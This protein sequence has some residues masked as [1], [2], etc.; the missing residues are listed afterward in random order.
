MAQ[1]PDNLQLNRLL[2][3][4]LSEDRRIELEAHLQQ[5]S[6]CAAEFGRLR[7]VARLL[8]AERE[9]Y[10]SAQRLSQIGLHRL[11]GRVERAME[12]GVLRI[13]RV[14]NA[15]AACVLVAGSA[16][17]FMRPRENRTVE[18]ATP[19][20]PPWVD[21]SVVSD[22][23]TGAYSTPAAAWYLAEDSSRDTSRADAVNP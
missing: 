4:E 16:W 18:I 6:M 19:A 8:E 11:H 21:V 1:C 17:L 15:I 23:P 20:A 22:S 7:E 10:F 5:C 2:D 3:G 14:L 13:V 9:G 12:D